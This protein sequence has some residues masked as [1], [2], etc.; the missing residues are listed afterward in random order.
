MKLKI[1]L[2][3]DS[4]SVNT[5]NWIYGLKSANVDVV[6]WSFS[7]SKQNIFYFLKGLVLAYKW[8]NVEK[9]D[10]I[11]GYRT[12]SYGFVASLLNHHP[13][14]I[15][16]QAS[17]DASSN[18]LLIRYLSRF[19]SAYA[20]KKADFIH[21]WAENMTHSLIKR[22]ADYNKIIILPRGV[23]LNVFKFKLKQFD[24]NNLRFIV[25][26]S[27]YPEYHID[28]VIKAFSIL[29]YKYNIKNCRLT[30]AG[31]GPLE[32][33]LKRLVLDL[34]IFDSVIFTGKIS[35]TDTAFNLYNND[36]YISMPDT[37]GASASLFE[38][39]ACGL[40]PIVSD[41]PANRE[42]I[43]DQVNGILIADFNEHNL[44]LKIFEIIN[45]KTFLL[46][47]IIRNRRM[48][49]EQLC[50]SKNMRKFVTHYNNILS[51]KNI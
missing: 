1:G 26:R 14:G 40:F 27:L 36:I 28:L 33:Q 34:D 5:Q 20:I 47:S 13:F 39:F 23:D 43:V 42:W 16:A 37:E 8:I 44:A 11:I 49:E 48:S 21:C 29:I 17:D 24:V 22:G 15:A 30:I 32:S 12:T 2:L 51:K 31:I 10:I 38:A 6:I 9:P 46:S 3:G 7:N 41:L 35:T 18:N 45:D 50:L 25:T 4:N 19:T